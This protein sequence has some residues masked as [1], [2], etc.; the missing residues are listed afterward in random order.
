[1]LFS[2]LGKKNIKR[3]IIK[4]LTV[5]N[6]WNF[7][8]LEPKDKNGQPTPPTNADFVIRAYGGKCGEI[9]E[10]KLNALCP[11]SWHWIK[12]NI[13][14]NTLIKRFKSLNYNISFNTA[15]QNSIGKGDLVK[16]YTE[17]YG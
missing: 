6:D 3:N 15:R 14:K 10:T 17:K 11:K 1:M 2:N 8:G 4:L 12:S 13:D 16:L 9:I 7:I 5:H